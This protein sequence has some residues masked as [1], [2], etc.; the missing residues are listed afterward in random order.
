MKPFRRLAVALGAALVLGALVPGAAAATTDSF[1]RLGGGDTTLRLDPGVA[2]ALT[3]AGVAVAPVDP[4]A[5]TRAGIAFPIT[6]GALAGGFNAID[7]SGG[8]RFTAGSTSVA[9]TDF[10]VV[11]GTTSGLLFA[12]VGGREYPVIALDLRHARVG[13]DGGATTIRGISARL[14]FLG[15]RLLNRAFDTRLFRGGL[16]LGH[17]D[18]RALG[19]DVAIRGGATTLA[20]DAGAG[21]AL[22]S[23]GVAPGVIGPATAGADGLRFPITGG[24]VDPTTLFG[25][26]RHSGGISLTRGST[27]VRLRDFVIDLDESPSLSARLGHRRVDILRLDIAGVAPVAEGATVTLGGI[28][29]RL[30]AAAAGA[31]NRAFGTRAF[32]EGL[33]LGT[34]TVRAQV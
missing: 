7:H 30:T 20:L 1:A 8:L 4:A 16:K 3:G 22:A 26:V 25:Q 9:L 14:T 10:R 24:T 12:T 6:G 33:L 28:E 27:V 21:A 15:A 11:T 18:V 13:Q 34:A 19:V 29:A 23:L 5:V 32:T 17:V 2:R 31:L